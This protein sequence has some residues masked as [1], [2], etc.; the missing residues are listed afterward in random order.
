MGS[1][2]T[3]AKCVRILT[4]FSEAS[5]TLQIGEIADRLRLPRSSAYRYVSALKTHGLVEQAPDGAGYR[6]GGRILELAATF[7]LTHLNT[8]RRRRLLGLASLRWRN[9]FRSS[10]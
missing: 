6:L 1:F 10:A 2:N 3:L 5:P 4:L 8:S 9:A 7:C